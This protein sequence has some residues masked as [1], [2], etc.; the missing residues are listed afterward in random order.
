[1][2]GDVTLT[3]QAA[4]MEAAVM[5]PGGTTVLWVG[6]VSMFAAFVYFYMLYAVSTP[7][8]R[9][10]HVVTMGAVGCASTSYL[11]MALGT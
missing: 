8:K 6:F 9:F 11:F 2:N 7:G 5:S 10:F 4:M 3:V 1:M